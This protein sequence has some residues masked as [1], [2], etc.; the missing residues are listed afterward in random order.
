MRKSRTRDRVRYVGATSNHACSSRVAERRDR[1]HREKLRS[2]RSSI[3]FSAPKSMRLISKKTRKS[4]NAKKARLEKQRAERIQRENNILI[5]RILDV[6]NKHERLRKKEFY[7]DR[8]HT[9]LTSL[10]R[11]TRSHAS[12]EMSR[13]NNAILERILNV[14]PQFSQAS[15]RAQE[16]ERQRI[17]KR[18]KGPVY[19]RTNTTKRPQGKRPFTAVPSQRSDAKQEQFS[20]A[21]HGTGGLEGLMAHLDIKGEPEGRKGLF[22]ASTRPKT[23]GGGL[24]GPKNP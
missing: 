3:D 5:R 12:R 24:R 6:D 1:L 17:M 11:R 10:N 9:K 15:W 20:E 7:L 4:R 2:V 16:K 14:R 13:Q 8:A 21:S 22:S 23:A 19:I 18:L